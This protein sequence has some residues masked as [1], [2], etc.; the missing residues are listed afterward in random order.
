MT[1]EE[2]T[3]ELVR[4][5]NVLIDDDD[6]KNVVVSMIASRIVG[7]KSLRDHPTIRVRMETDTFYPSVNL[8]GL[9]NGICGSVEE[10]ARAGAGLLCS[11]VN[12]EGGYLIAFARTDRMKGVLPVR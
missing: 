8:I 10:G 5:L 7:A 2:F 11:V 6:V 4:R 3:D 9:L 12:K 1:N